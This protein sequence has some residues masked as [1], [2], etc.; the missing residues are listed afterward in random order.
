MLVD[1]LMLSPPQF[2]HLLLLAD[3]GAPAIL[4]DAP[5][6][7][8]LADAGSP[9][10]LADAPDAAM[11]ADA[12]APAVL[13]VIAWAPLAVMLAGAGAPAVPEIAPAVVM[14]TDAD[15][16]D[17]TGAGTGSSKASAASAVRNGLTATRRG[18]RP[19]M[20][21]GRER[22]EASG[23]VDSIRRSSWLEAEKL[24]LKRRTTFR[25]SM[26]LLWVFIRNL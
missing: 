3:A 11:L 8:M 18:S 10:V 2:W 14:L 22:R 25:S 23:N 17:G 4:A 13:A 24:L 5:L 12:R 19:T 21:W 16:G 15:G 9:A 20:R 6:T 26:G 7:V 1:S